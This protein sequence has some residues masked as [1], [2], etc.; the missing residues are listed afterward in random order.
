MSEA[1]DGA[2]ERS[3]VD[4][5]QQATAAALAVLRHDKC[6]EVL[7]VSIMAYPATP[8]AQPYIDLHVS[9]AAAVRVFSLILDPAAVTEQRE[10][11]RGQTQVTTA[12]CHAYGVLVR[13]VHVA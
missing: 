10:P 13:L 7:V 2:R 3:T 6:P 11:E 9:S 4:G 1:W 5:L 12:S 8:N